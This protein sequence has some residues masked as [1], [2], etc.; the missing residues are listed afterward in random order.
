VYSD[1]A[2]ILPADIDIASMQTAAYL[3]AERAQPLDNGSDTA[4]AA[5]R[6]I[7]GGD[8]TVV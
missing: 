7:E 3:N 5:R 6:T 8:E 4:H 1:A 2:N